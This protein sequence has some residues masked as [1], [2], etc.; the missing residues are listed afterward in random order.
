MLK[1]ILFTAVFAA[2]GMLA[3]AQWFQTMEE[4]LD[5]IKDSNSSCTLGFIDEV[6][7]ELLKKYTD[8]DL[9]FGI[10]NMRRG[11]IMFA[12][13]N[14][15]AAITSYRKAV[16]CYVKNNRKGTADE[17][18]AYYKMAR[19][20][21][22]Q[23]KPNA[24]LLHYEQSAKIFDKM[25]FSLDLRAAESFNGLGHAYNRKERY[26]EAFGYLFKAMN[27]YQGAKS[28]KMTTTPQDI[29]FSDVYYNMGVACTGNGSYEKAA[30]YYT[31]S[32]K[33]REEFLGKNS[34]TAKMTREK[35][36]DVS[37]RQA[38]ARN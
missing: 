33:I 2:V 14:Y 23:S 9:R 15:D 1:K 21:D 24:A 4:K 19:A 34:P 6:E 5:Y 35:L 17:A 11:Y 25:E 13:G 29:E 37:S 18:Y 36:E 7:K 32:L 31:K 12:G 27:I 30:E 16:A 22:M 20:E 10:T 38:A 3:T 26:N 8:K 28:A